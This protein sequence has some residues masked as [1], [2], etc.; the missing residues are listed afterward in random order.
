[1]IQD[2]TVKKLLTL[3]QP[4]TF[5]AQ[6]CICFEGQPGSEMYIILRGSVGIYVNSAIGRLV[7]VSKISGGDFFGEMSIF[8]NLPRSA[9]CMALEETVCVSI[10][11]DRLTD[12]LV[13]CPELAVK[14]LENMSGRIRRLD[15]ALYKT[16]K[17]AENLNV[18]E[19]EVPT[20]YSYSHNYANPN[21][22]N[23]RFVEEIEAHC[24][25][26]SKGITVTNIKRQFLTEKKIESDG[27]TRYVEFEPFWNEIWHCPH[28]HYS[29]HYLSFFK[30]LPFK[31]DHI[32][33]LLN[34][35]YL[36]AIEK[37]EFAETEFDKLFIW[38]IQTIHINEAVNMNDNLLIGKLWL[39]LYWLFA[40]AVDEK[41]EKYCAEKALPYL[42]AAYEEGA[43]PDDYSKQCIA[44]TI[45]SLSALHGTI[46]DAK[47]YCGLAIAGKDS[48]IRSHALRM[49]ESLQK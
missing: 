41:M 27:R 26:C 42:K 13:T 20:E 12:F 8:D 10:N 36:P 48:D 19:F 25:I 18:K 2:Q 32:N 47:K 49:R 6:D 43:I 23:P 31:R 39:D 30:M 37:A 33:K 3:C 14:L 9:T 38:Y 4:R 34:E 24:P 15:N 1:M 17:Y 46:E 5:K 11:K 22:D 40:D 21:K 45:T 16:D 7:E 44:L 29:N 35:Q 28:C